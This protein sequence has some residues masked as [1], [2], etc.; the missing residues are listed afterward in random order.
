V[1]VPA[2]ADATDLYYQGE[3]KMKAG[4]FAG[5]IADLRASLSLRRSLLTLTTLGQAYFDAGDLKNAERTLRR[6]GSYP[7]AM[8]LLARL[9]QQRGQTSKAREVYKRFVA[10]HPNH[11]KAAWARTMV[12]AL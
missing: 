2:G 10:Q 11:S 12:D 5:A 7:R 6:A 3:R 1:Q 4:D 9:H 8:L